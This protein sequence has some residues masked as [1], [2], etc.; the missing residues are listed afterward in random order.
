[1]MTYAGAALRNAKNAYGEAQISTAPQKKLLIMLYDGAIMNLM[2]AEKAIVNG[3]FETAHL[4]LVK[5]Q[6]I[7]VEL[8]ATLNFEFGGQI[9]QSLYKLYDFFY[10]TLVE[11]NVSKNVE[12]VVQ[13]RGFLEALRNTWL[14]I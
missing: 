11:A 7:L 3:Q 13:V 4:K 6:D 2:I 1:M 8:M 9:A 14:E 5:T 10:L 12:K